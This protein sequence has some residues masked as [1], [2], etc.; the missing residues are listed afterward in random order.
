MN[1]KAI[2]C[3]N[4]RPTP[5]LKKSIHKLS[6]A[7]GNTV[8]DL[9]C[10]NGR[11]SRYLR[12]LGFNVFSFDRKPDFGQELDLARQKIPKVPNPNLII[13]NYVLC[14]MKPEERTHLANEINRISEA[15]CFLIVELYNA[16]TS[17]PYTTEDIRE[18]FP[19]WETRH[20]I[21]DR[22]ILQKVS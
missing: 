9:G 2:R 3:N 7:E 18:M 1:F 14:F 4:D 6:L 17:H 21:K 20:L 11:N 13:C 19:E 22:F 5:Y 16:K 12:S 15:G 8:I 10:G